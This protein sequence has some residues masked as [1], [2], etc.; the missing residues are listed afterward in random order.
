MWSTQS[1]SSPVCICYSLCSNRRHF[2]LK[3]CL[4]MCVCFAPRVH[5]GLEQLMC[6]CWDQNPKVRFACLWVCGFVACPSKMCC[7]ICIL[8]YSSITTCSGYLLFCCPNLPFS[9]FRCM[10]SMSYAL[11]QTSVSRHT[12]TH[13]HTRI[14]LTSCLPPQTEPWEDSRSSE[15][16]ERWRTLSTEYRYKNMYRGAWN[17]VNPIFWMAETP[18]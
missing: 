4:F 18:D 12:R 7:G 13:I 8:Q 17:G 9:H 3:I 5:V 15:P 6:N 2:L 10:K 16:N 11:A 14:N 1:I